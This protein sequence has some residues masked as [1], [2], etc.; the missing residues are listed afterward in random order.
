MYIPKRS[1][2]N[3]PNFNNVFRKWIPEEK[4]EPV[5]TKITPIAVVSAEDAVK[6]LKASLASLVKDVMDDWSKK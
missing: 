5:Y 3:M 2:G 1:L 6:N 4:E